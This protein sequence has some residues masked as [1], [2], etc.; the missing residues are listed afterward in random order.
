[1]GRD[2]AERI[3]AP[4]SQPLAPV[5]ENGAEGATAGTVTDEAIFVAQFLIVGIDDD[6]RQHAAAMTQDRWRTV[7][8]G[9]SGHHP[10]YS[11]PITLRA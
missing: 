5:F 8:L 7:R 6:G 3:L 10:A 2:I 4:G 1:M 11:P 9:L